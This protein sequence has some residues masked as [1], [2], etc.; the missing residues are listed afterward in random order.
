MNWLEARV[1]EIR[2]LLTPSDEGSHW[3]LFFSHPLGEPV[4]AAVVDG[5]MAEMDS[6]LLRGLMEIIGGVPAAAC[7][8]AVIRGDGKPRPEDHQMWHD[9][10][11]LMSGTNKRLLGFVVVGTKA[12]WSA[13][14][15]DLD[16]AV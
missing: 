16:T 1:G 8:V 10:R 3:S 13:D 9:L 7:L 14:C 12:H 5:A 6:E 15:G 11:A 4:V 2:D